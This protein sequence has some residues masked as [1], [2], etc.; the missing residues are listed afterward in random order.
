M[1]GRKVLLMK[2]F[3]YRVLN[4]LIID[5]YRRHKTT[6]LDVLLDKGFE[7]S[8]TSFGRMLNVL[9]GKAALLL[10]EKLP[11]SYRRVMNMR[12]AQ[13][14]SVHEI[15]LATGQSRNAVAVQAHRGLEKLKMLYN[16]S[17]TTAM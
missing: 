15:S 10:I 14:L 3:L 17:V 6:S 7:P 2:A 9:D 1:K 16:N 12:Y 5:E 13:D 4:N 11:Q 8:D